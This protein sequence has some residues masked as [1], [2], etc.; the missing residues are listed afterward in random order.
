MRSQFD[1]FGFG[2]RFSH[3]FFLGVILANKIHLC[4]LQEVTSA[5]R[6]PTPGSTG[7][8]FLWCRLFNTTGQTVQSYLFKY[9]SKHVVRHNGQVDGWHTVGYVHHRVYGSLDYFIC[10]QTS[11]NALVPG[12]YCRCLKLTAKQ[13]SH[14]AVS[15][16]TCVLVVCSIT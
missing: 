9:L 2:L 14:P 6:H 5:A 4:P 13:T 8:A 10:S 3:H 7:N 11:R 1:A 12:F 15:T 16:W